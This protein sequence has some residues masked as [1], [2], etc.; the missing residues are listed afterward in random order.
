MGAALGVGGVGAWEACWWCGDGGLGWTC[1]RMRYARA[2]YRKQGVLSNAGVQ[3][4]SDE[5]SFYL[6]GGALEV[7]SR[8]CESKRER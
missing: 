7:T 2:C 3:D 5:S 4:L 1:A 6:P 8:T